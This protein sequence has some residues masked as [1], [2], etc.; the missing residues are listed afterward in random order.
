MAEMILPGT[1]IEVRAEG[2]IVPGP[3]SI[4]NVA[5]V[6]T[7][8]RGPLNTPILPS[9]IGEAREIFGQYDALDNPDEANSP[10]TLVRALEL[11]YANGAQ[12]VYAVRVA[13]ADGADAAAPAVFNLGTSGSNNVVATSV[14]PGRGYNDT[15]IIAETGSGGNL[16]VTITVGNSTETWRDVPPAA[17]DFADVLNGDSTTYAYA[18]QSSTRGGSN[19]FDFDASAASGDVA[20]GTP[21]ALSS[22][23]TSGAT[24]TAGEYTAGLDVLTNENVHIVVLAGQTADALGAALTAHVENASTDAIK[25]DRI[26]VIG[27]GSDDLGNLIA[28]GMDSSRIVFVGPG[29]YVNDAVSGSEVPLTGAFSAAAVAGLISSLSPHFSPTNKVLRVNGVAPR[30]NGTQLEQLILGRVLALEDR[31]G[32]IK[33][34]QGITTSS[35]TAYKQ[36]TTRRIVD[37]AKFGVRSACEPFI[38]KLNNERVRAA[39]KGTINGFLADMVDQEM[40][41]SYELE[42]TATREQ[43][44]RGIC[45]VTMILRPTFSIDYIRV[46]MYLE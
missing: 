6:G 20:A 4:G 33:I 44:I 27:G 26:G 24:A 17:A 8:R 22:P 12:R 7:A 42:V 39:M 43:Q 10:L 9:D 41:I 1:Y 15:E 23:G 45:Q 37:Y 35:D 38:G 13:R 32:V 30:F 46:T 31:N 14:A 34:V 16:N 5:I 29:I 25:R 36:I 18:T 11:A 21:A 40:L 19:F 3:I 28:H 2:L